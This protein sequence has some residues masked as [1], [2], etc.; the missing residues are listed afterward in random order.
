MS[1]PH[2]LRLFS[3][4]AL[5]AGSA[6]A[7]DFPFANGTFDASGK[8][9]PW[10]LQEVRDYSNTAIG[11]L[12]GKKSVA[13]KDNAATPSFLAYKS[14][15]VETKVFDTVLDLTQVEGTVYL[16][17]QVDDRATLTVV[18][19][20]NQS[21]APGHSGFNESYTVNGT[22][23]WK[24]PQSYSEFPKPIPG[25]KAYQ[26]KL[27]YQNTANLTGKHPEGF[28]DFDGVN[29]FLMHHE[30][31]PI[32]GQAFS[33]TKDVLDLGTKGQDAIN[34]AFAYLQ[35]QV[36]SIHFDAQ[37]A[38]NWV[39]TVNPPDFPFLDEGEMITDIA[40]VIEKLIIKAES[41]LKSKTTA[42][43]A[44]VKTQLTTSFNLGVATLLP[45][46]VFRADASW[47]KECCGSSGFW[48]SPTVISAGITSTTG[49]ASFNVELNLGGS[50][51]IEV[52]TPAN[53]EFSVSLSLEHTGW[54][55]ARFWP[56]AAGPEDESNHK[57]C[58][59]RIMAQPEWQ[60]TYDA[61]GGGGA[62][63]K[64]NLGV[65]RTLANIPMM[66]EVEATVSIEEK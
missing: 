5:F 61:S 52:T 59:V 39:K 43:L 19:A 49:S 29:V 28:I 25:G 62:L 15:E 63:L 56:P 24:K 50:V 27:D 41:T 18:E 30:C 60:A 9:K 65:A 16:A 10:T 26:V 3:I 36:D 44:T 17:I 1:S 45:Q 64:V 20:P 53:I 2:P 23:L 37:A 21:V 38:A 22:A 47:K 13:E 4:L 46:G 54:S 51:G 32:Q 6:A 58:S 7:A 48:S 33:A 8:L 55:N 12:T 42:A 34:H 40:G 14:D 57:G 11:D 31:G 66:K 35:G